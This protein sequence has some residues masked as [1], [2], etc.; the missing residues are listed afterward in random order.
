MPNIRFV[1][2]NFRNEQAPILVKFPDLGDYQQFIDKVKLIVSEKWHQEPSQFIIEQTSDIAASDAIKVA[3]RQY[4]WLAD[5]R[6]ALID[7]LS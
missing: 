7:K 6:L 4:D 1:K 5:L 2:F 3:N